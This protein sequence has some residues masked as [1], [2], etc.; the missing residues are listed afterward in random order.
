MTKSDSAN[1]AWRK[2]A[3]VAAITAGFVI[4]GAWGALVIC[5]VVAG[6]LALRGILLETL[7]DGLHDPPSMVLPISPKSAKSVGAAP[8]GLTGECFKKRHLLG[9]CLRVTCTTIEMA[10]GALFYASILCWVMGWKMNLAPLPISIGIVAT[11]L[12][13]WW[14]DD[15]DHLAVIAALRKQNGQAQA[16]DYILTGTTLGCIAGLWWP[17]YVLL[18]CTVGVLLYVA[19]FVNRLERGFEI[20]PYL[21]NITVK[22]WLI[23]AGWRGLTGGFFTFVLLTPFIDVKRWLHVFVIMVLSSWCFHWNFWY[24][25]VLKD[26]PRLPVSEVIAAGIG[27]SVMAAGPAFIVAWWWDPSAASIGWCV[28]L[29]VAGVLNGTREDRIAKTIVS[30]RRMLFDGLIVAACGIVCAAVI[31]EAS[32]RTFH[33]TQTTTWFFIDFAGYLGFIIGRVCGC[34]FGLRSSSCKTPRLQDLL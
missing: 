12:M 15:D 30:Q 20:A 17:N 33:F 3:L 5:L 7:P 26:V 11:A 28:A 8:G 2:T 32:R 27:A 34:R 14:E 10:G 24:R 1:L 9:R 21:L 29:V 4:G 18:F 13:A 25:G 16:I 31:G 22:Q 6:V 23:T 19:H